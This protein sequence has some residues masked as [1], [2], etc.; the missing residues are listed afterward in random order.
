MKFSLILN[1]FK[2]GGRYFSGIVES[3]NNKAKLTMRKTYGYKSF[4]TIETALYHAIANLPEPKTTH[5]LC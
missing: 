4:H 1:W 5:R 2:A 3:F